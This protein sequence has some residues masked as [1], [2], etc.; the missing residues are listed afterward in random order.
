MPWVG[1]SRVKAAMSGPSVSEGCYQFTLGHV[2]MEEVNLEPFA[3][4]TEYTQKL[5]SL[6][7]SGS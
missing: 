6:G 5:Q 4:G 2:K 7:L 3:V 1:S